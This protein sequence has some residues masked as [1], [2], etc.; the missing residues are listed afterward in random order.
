[1]EQSDVHGHRPN[2]GGPGRR[3]SLSL[4]L[5]DRRGSLRGGRDDGPRIRNRPLRDPVEQRSRIRME[6]AGRPLSRQD[7]RDVQW[8]G[9]GDPSPRWCPPAN[10]GGQ[11]DNLEPP[12][13]G[14]L[15]LP[16]PN[17][18]RL[19]ADIDPERARGGAAR[20]RLA[21][22][23]PR[24]R[25]RPTALERRARRRKLVGECYRVCDSSGGLV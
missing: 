18:R 8:D 17:G 22:S 2:G 15:R 14:R 13:A 3:I 21:A 4:Q 1:M 12:T 5:D 7:E 25:L 11:P 20:R 6:R 16:D 19:A 24:H 10:G 9:D 23:F